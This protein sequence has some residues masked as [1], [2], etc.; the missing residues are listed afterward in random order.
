MDENMIRELISRQGE[1]NLRMGLNFLA[2]KQCLINKGLI[3]EEDFA[4]A[5]QQ[6]HRES[7]QT[8]LGLEDSTK[9]EKHN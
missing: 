1:N 6:V 9:K 7:K 4:V 2:I 3:T 5:V 8:L